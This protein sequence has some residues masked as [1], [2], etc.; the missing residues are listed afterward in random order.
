M[1]ADHPLRPVKRLAD[2]ALGAISGELAGRAIRLGRSPIDSARETAQ[3]AIAHRA[4]FGSLGPAVLRAARL[5]HPVPL[6]PR[7]ES[8]EPDAGPVELQ[9]PA[10]APGRHRRGPTL[11]RR[12]RQ[13]GSQAEAAILGP[14]HGRRHAD[15]CLGFVQELQTQG[16]RPAQGR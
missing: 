4:V 8:R 5:Q 2:R 3:C 12:G 7:H 15:R 16:W 14:L 9:P 6:V 10:R 11:L 13:S 1:P